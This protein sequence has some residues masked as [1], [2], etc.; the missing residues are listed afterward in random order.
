MD[1]TNAK[2]RESYP[3]IQL[4]GWKVCMLCYSPSQNLL[5]LFQ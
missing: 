3:G 4:N 5:K 1:A 2:L